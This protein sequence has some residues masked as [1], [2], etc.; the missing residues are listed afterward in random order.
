[1]EAGIMRALDGLEDED[2][3]EMGPREIETDSESDDFELEDEET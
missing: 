1:M 2:S 3:G